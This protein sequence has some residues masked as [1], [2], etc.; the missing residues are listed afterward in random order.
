MSFKECA[1][2]VSA[3]FKDKIIN[4]LYNRYGSGI[5]DI[6]KIYIDLKK[7]KYQKN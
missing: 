7:D 2:I 6:Y 1:N 5:I 3:H 4:S